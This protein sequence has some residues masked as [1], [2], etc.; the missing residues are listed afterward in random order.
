MDCKTEWIDYAGTGRF[1][2][3]IT[4]YLRE[5]PALAPFYAYS[6]VRPDFKKAM[7]ARDAFPTDRR[8]L[9]GE[10]E[11]QY[12]GIEASEEV[13]RNIRLLA[14]PGTY[15]ICTAHQPNLFTGYLYFVYKILHTIRLAADLEQQYPG[16]HFV[17]VYY[18][19][20][21]DADL[22][23][24]GTV[25]LEGRTYRWETPQKG[26][27]G[28]MRTEGLE[29]LIE[30]VTAHL[31]VHAEAEE[32]RRLVRE[33]YLGHADIQTATLYLV[34]ALFG[35]FGLIVVIAD[36]PGFKRAFTPV[37]R[38]ELLEERSHAIVSK[39]I[40]GFPSEYHVQA[41][42]RE[43][44]LFYLDEQLRERIVKNKDRWEVLHTDIS[45]TRDRLEAEL[46]AH[47][48]R[49]SPNVILRGLLQETILPDIAFIGGGGE[50]AYWLE[51]KDLFG[52]FGVP[53]PLLM[54]RHSVLWIPE[55]ASRKLR[56]L[57]IDA[58][59][60]FRD[61]EALVADYVKQHTDKTL[62]LKRE[63]AAMEQFYQGL[64]QKALAID[65]TLGP[66]VG[67]YRKR[68]VAALGKLEQKFL[69]AEKKKFAWQTEAIRSVKETLFPGGS[70]QER[71]E[72]L[73]PFYAAYG[74]DFIR[75]VYESLDP[76]NRAFQIIRCG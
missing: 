36:T 29:A 48:E 73:L 46:A 63:Y 41:T 64:E 70:L 39:T 62:V 32:I 59:S 42:P 33:A 20:S 76:L 65:I 58:A 25:H 23:E 12:A 44:N 52:H 40:S 27:V 14:E 61:T 9:T 30:A 43:I 51:L 11:Q 2:R 54:L 26:A 53:F 66:S 57:E 28:R 50:L 22:D 38:E 49:F 45:F 71:V 19:G 75:T 18:M 67:A 4:D 37:L 31:G 69:R 5:A 21:E 47:P 6:P 55:A 35:G 34:N 13:S 68:A 16:K 60:L 10:L 1:S 72:N 56:K 8:L 15:T 3:L 7:A 74:P 17:P 24:L